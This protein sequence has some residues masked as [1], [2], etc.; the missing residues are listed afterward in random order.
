MPNSIQSTDVLVD[1]Y[2]AQDEESASDFTFIL[3]SDGSLKSF[4]IPQHLMND[5]P[6]EAQ[7]ILELFGIDDIHE[8]TNKTIH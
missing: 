3:N 4:S 2:D 7:L 5:V 8:L 6:E 1:E